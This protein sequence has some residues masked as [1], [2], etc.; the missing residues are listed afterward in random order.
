M[1][2]EIP[3]TL[4]GRD[5][6]EGTAARRKSRFTELA[7]LW[8]TFLEWLTPLLTPLKDFFKAWLALRLERLAERP[9]CLTDL[10]RLLTFL[11]KFLPALFVARLTLRPA[12]FAFL[13]MF[14]K[15]SAS[16][17]VAETQ[18]R[19]KLATSIRVILILQVKWVFSVGLTTDHQISGNW[20]RKVPVFLKSP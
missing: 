7:V 5:F 6:F 20:P 19:A 11:E 16:A 18:I 1:S 2:R 9:R 4:F 3:R 14:P 10:P 15:M 17:T 8:K 12:L 13:P